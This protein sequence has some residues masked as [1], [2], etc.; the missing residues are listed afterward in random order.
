MNDGLKITIEELQEIHRLLQSESGEGVECPSFSRWDRIKGILG[1]NE[2]YRSCPPDM[3]EPAWAQYNAARGVEDTSHRLYNRYSEDWS[4]EEYM[5]R[6]ARMKV[7]REKVCEQR[8]LIM[9]GFTDLFKAGDFLISS[10]VSFAGIRQEEEQAG[11]ETRTIFFRHED[12]REESIGEIL[13]ETPPGE[14][15]A[16]RDEAQRIMDAHG[17]KGEVFIW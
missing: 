12:G 17:K 13:E 11:E 5:R 7:E 15:E 4:S 6:T 14:V 2:D 16:C 3:P 10:P 1:G 8:L 9:Q